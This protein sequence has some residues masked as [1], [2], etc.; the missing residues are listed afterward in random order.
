MSHAPLHQPPDPAV[1]AARSGVRNRVLAALPTEELDRLAPHLERLEPELR[2][3]LLDV[4]RPIAHVYFPEGMVVSVLSVMADGTAVETAT[5]GREGM[6]GLPVFLGTDQMSAQAFCQVPGPALR[7]PADAFRRIVA[8]S[9]ALTLSLHRYT[10]ALFTLVAQGSAC[11]R[12]HTMPERCARWLLHTHDRVERDEFPLTHHFL[13]QMLGVR[14]ATVT[15]AMGALQQAGAVDYQMGR[16]R[17]R[18]RGALERAACEC[19]TI[20]A[21]EFDRLLVPPGAPPRRV[22]SALRDVATEE[23]GRT[24]LRDGA[25]RGEPRDADSPA[26]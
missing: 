15:E 22:P 13:S 18:D 3:V 1:H 7:M 26:S 4:D 2:A 16:V 23:A 10:Q 8:E 6:L 24:V 17:V 5:V 21:R 25:P 14:R 9:P 19:Y 12:L 20:I 11:N